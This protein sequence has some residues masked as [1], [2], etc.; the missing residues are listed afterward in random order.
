M[1]KNEFRGQINS[2]KISLEKIKSHLVMQ[3][4]DLLKKTNKNFV[5][6]FSFQVISEDSF[7]EEAL[8]NGLLFS[9]NLL[10][11]NILKINTL[12]PLFYVSSFNLI[13]N[14][15]QLNNSG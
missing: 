2:K 14:R 6:I 5:M 4:K 9:F 12:Q 15:L 1:I 13:P 8:I 3:N 7:L 10:L 11:K